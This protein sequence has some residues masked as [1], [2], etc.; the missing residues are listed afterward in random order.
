AIPRAVRANA[1]AFLAA[2]IAKLG[3]RGI[4][5]AGKLLA[6]WLRR[7]DEARG[8]LAR[9]AALM[10]RG[11]TGGAFFRNLYRDFLAASLP[12]CDEPLLAAGHER[13]A[14]IAP[15]WTEAA[16]LLERAAAS[17]EQGALDQA[18]ALFGELARREREAMELLA[19]VRDRQPAA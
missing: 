15:L 2:P 6:D 14:A 11:G 7:G 13:Y 18:G 17:G 12:I 1:E 3:P 19:G 16:G 5:K 9:I 4:A 8:E 10:E